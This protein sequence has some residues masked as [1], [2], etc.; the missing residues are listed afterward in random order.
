[1]YKD[2][3]DEITNLF[4]GYLTKKDIKDPSEISS[5]ERS[6]FDSISNKLNMQ[7]QAKNDLIQAENAVI[8]VIDKSSNKLYRRY[9]ELNYV[10]NSNGLLLEGEDLTGKKSKIIFM[11]NSAIVKFNELRGK[12][13]DK[14]K[15]K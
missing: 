10:E 9:L 11:S 6:I 1:M 8:E 13:I 14:P 4:M 5:L 15:C 7:N 3:V 2:I 12:G